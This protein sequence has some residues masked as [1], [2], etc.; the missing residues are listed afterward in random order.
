M[1]ITVKRQTKYLRTFAP[2]YLKLDGRTV[3]RIL[4]NEEVDL[5]LDFP[6]ATLS[7]RG[8]RSSKQLVTDGDTILI[9]DN[10]INA[11]A[12]WGGIFL[13]LGGQ[14]IFDLGSWPMAILTW[15]GLLGILASLFIKRFKLEKEQ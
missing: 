2:L 10:L 3:A 14:F 9:K 13:I 11:L 7:I 15:I 5:P 4:E 12:F 6:T 1:T 8:S